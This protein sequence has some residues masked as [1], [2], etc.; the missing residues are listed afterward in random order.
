MKETRGN[1]RVLDFDPL[2]QELLVWTLNTPRCLKHSAKGQLKV[3]RIPKVGESTRSKSVEIAETVGNGVDD[4][5]C[6]AP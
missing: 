4:K 6:F 3:A 1:G 2:A 5:P